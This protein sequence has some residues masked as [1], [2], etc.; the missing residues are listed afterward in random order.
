MICVLIPIAVDLECHGCQG[1]Y[2][3]SINSSKKWIVNRNPYSNIKRTLLLKG[4]PNFMQFRQIQIW[5]CG[6]DHV[7]IDQAFLTFLELS[8]DCRV[9]PLSD[10][11]KQNCSNSI[12]NTLKLLQPCAKSLI[13]Y[14]TTTLWLSY[15]ALMHNKVYRFIPKKY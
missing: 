14:N 11:L 4:P 9:S 10:W 6:G 1:R 7:I 12:S 15:T 3:N 8:F 2:M 5:F 13:R